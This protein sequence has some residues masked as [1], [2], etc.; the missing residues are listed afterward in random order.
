MNWGHAWK[1]DADSKSHGKAEYTVK[2]ETRTYDYE[3]SCVMMYRLILE[4]NLLQTIFSQI[5]L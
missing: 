3:E 5:I 4:R 2:G 1:N